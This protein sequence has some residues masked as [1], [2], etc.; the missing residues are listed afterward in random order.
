MASLQNVTGIFKNAKSRTI[1]LITIAIIIGGLFLAVSGLRKSASTSEGN[2]VLPRA[3][4]ISGAPTIIGGESSQERARLTKEADD[5]T[6]WNAAREGQSALPSSF[7][8]PLSLEGQDINEYNQ[9]NKT[10]HAA[11]NQLDTLINQAEQREPDE[12]GQTTH[13]VPSIAE[14]QRLSAAEEARTDAE[15]AQLQAQVNS[16]TGARVSSGDSSDNAALAGA[17]SSEVRQLLASWNTNQQQY[18]EGAATAAAAGP[19]TFSGATSS[20]AAGSKTPAGPP[21]FKAGDILFGVL[22][23]EVNTDQPGPI[24]ATIEVGPYKGAKLL[25]S[26]KKGGK[27]AN[28]AILEFSTMTLPH[29]QNSIDVSAYAIDSDTARTAMASDVDHHYVMRYGALFASSFMAGWADAIAQSGTTTIQYP[30]GTQQTY[31]QPLDHNDK[32][33]Y[34]LGEVGREASDEVDELFDRPT[35]ITIYSGTGI[36]ILYMKDVPAPSADPAATTR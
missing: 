30:D 26:V 6:V 8:Q 10:Q 3:P 19:G 25:G 27:W 14:M 4:K 13:R 9:K 23:T 16:E 5:Q 2:V 22:Q 18:T 32:L 17:M 29:Y 12:Q 33:A 7:N 28:G 24:M 15:A 20:G 34:A 31:H 21:L 36:G 11:A 35:T 1:F